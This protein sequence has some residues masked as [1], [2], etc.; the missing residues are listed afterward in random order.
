MLM[1][2]LMTT[3]SSSFFPNQTNKSVRVRRIFRN[4][5]RLIA[6]KSRVVFC[7]LQICIEKLKV[8]LAAVPVHDIGIEFA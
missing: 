8:K 6:F 1:L 5:D 4:S 7:F 3:R 2:F